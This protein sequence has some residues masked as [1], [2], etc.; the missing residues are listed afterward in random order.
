MDLPPG[1]ALETIVKNLADI[2]K[3]GPT[4]HDIPEEE[5][6]S[7]DVV[8]AA[9]RKAVG[10]KSPLQT[11]FD[12]RLPIDTIPDFVLHFNSLTGFDA[13]DFDD[14]FG[15]GM[16]RKAVTDAINHSVACDVQQ[17]YK[18]ECGV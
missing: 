3:F 4:Y 5:R 1:I 10:E 15:E 8:C 13:A 14:K 17:S 2:A 7:I 6:I 12:V 11:S 9:V 16:A 18:F